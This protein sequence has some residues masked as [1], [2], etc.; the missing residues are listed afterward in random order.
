MRTSEGRDWPYVIGQALLALLG[1]GMIA[2]T[3][4]VEDAEPHQAVASKLQPLG[5]TYGWE[6]CSL[7]DCSEQKAGAIVETP[8]GYVV[9]ASGTIIPYGDKKIKRSKDE[10]FHLCTHGG[11][12]DGVVICLYVPDEAF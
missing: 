10:L 12:P 7:T 11:K 3:F 9:K 8:K 4:F 6:C 2:S 5:W 1:A